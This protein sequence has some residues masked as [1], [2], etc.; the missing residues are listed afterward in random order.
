LIVKK[1]CLTLLAGTLLASA[2]P[3]LAAEKEGLFDFADKERWIIRARLI[4][5]SPDESSTVTGLSANVDADN[6]FTP[7]LDF[8]YFFNDNIAAELIL[9]TSKHEMATDTGIDL[10]EVWVIPPTL[11][12]QY[13][14]NPDGKIRPYA[15][16]GLGYI[17][18]YN[19]DSGA[20]NDIEY[21]DGMSYALQVGVDVEID[22]NWAFNADVKKLYHSTDVSI[23]GGSITADVDLNP[24]VLGVGVAYRF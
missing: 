23:N 15:G 9:A 12:M 1:I 10:G 8:T 5:V 3:T 19:E 13:H 7:E 11:T 20:V 21:D 6:G 16:A 14:F 17:M 2:S 18:Y 4:D 24:W 22:K